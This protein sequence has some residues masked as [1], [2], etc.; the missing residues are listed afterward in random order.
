MEQQA[1]KPK[2]N[3]VN[4]L[5]ALPFAVFA[6]LFG[7]G[8]SLGL[9]FGDSGESL[10]HLL[11]GW[12]VLLF[13]SNGGAAIAQAVFVAWPGQRTRTCARVFAVLAIGV[14]STTVLLIVLV[15]HPH[16]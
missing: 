3:F 5:F 1:Q 10:Q 8:I 7:Y 15:F 14:L 13:A 4:L 11:T 12:I 6:A 2:R 9:D 16:D